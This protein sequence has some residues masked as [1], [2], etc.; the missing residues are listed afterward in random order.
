M[1][2]ITTQ[3][4]IAVERKQFSEML[5]TKDVEAQIINYEKKKCY[6]SEMICSEITL[7]HSFYLSYKAQIWK[8]YL[9]R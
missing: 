9:A 6:S 1:F 2:Y 8:A 3:V 5:K 4:W 7:K